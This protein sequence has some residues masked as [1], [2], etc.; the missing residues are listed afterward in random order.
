MTRQSKHSSIGLALIL[1]GALALLGNLGLFGGLGGLVGA[2]LLAGAG[3]FL[4]RYQQREPRQ[5]W[6]FIVSFAFFGLALA[7][8]SGPLGGSYF[9][10]MFAAGFAL[11]FRRDARQWWALIPAGVLA[12][13][14]LVSGL[15]TLLRPF[16]AGPVFFLGLAATFGLVYRQGQ[17]WAVYPAIAALVLAL[18]S[19]S[20]TGSWLL[21]LVLL[22]LGFY[23]LSRGSPAGQETA[24]RQAAEHTTP[25]EPPRSTELTPG[26]DGPQ[27]KA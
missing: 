13:L 4:L 10:L 7:A 16:D 15:E 12:T 1:L 22:G 2:L 23:L 8:I 18:L 20:F 17:R 3:A 14:A 5:L 11:V 9:L 19:T 24:P 25:L 26:E 21:P 6:A 27:T